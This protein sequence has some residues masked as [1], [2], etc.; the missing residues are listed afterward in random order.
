MVIGKIWRSIAHVIGKYNNLIIA[1]N[2]HF[3]IDI[4]GH[5]HELSFSGL[6]AWTVYLCKLRNLNKQT[7]QQNPQTSKKHKTTKQ[8]LKNP[9]D[10]RNKMWLLLFNVVNFCLHPY[11]MVINFSSTSLAFQSSIFTY[12]MSQREVL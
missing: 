3:S 2:I 9:Q 5:V 8:N 4:H 1:Y 12:F 10:G 7:K 6:I 11:T